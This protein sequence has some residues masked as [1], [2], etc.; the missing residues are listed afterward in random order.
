MSARFGLLS[1]W[2][3]SHLWGNLK[4]ADTISQTVHI[5]TDLYVHKDEYI[6]IYRY[7][8]MYL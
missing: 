5:Y 6:T 8:C 3:E 1:F 2:S 4:S 7:M